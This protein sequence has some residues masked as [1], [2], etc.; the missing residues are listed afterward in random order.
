MPED[1]HW[2]GEGDEMA[3]LWGVVVEQSL[4]DRGALS[5]FEVLAE[6]PIGAWRLLLV[7]VD[8]SDLADAVAHLRAGMVPAHEESWYA[9]FFDDRRLVVV[10]QDTVFEVTPDART[11]EPVVMHGLTRGV[12]LEQLDFDPCTV[13]DARARFGLAAQAPAGV[14]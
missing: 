3:G 7:R 14:L 10:F 12:P 11:W 9:H 5:P 1:R 2:S 6:L 13:A 4:V 8:E